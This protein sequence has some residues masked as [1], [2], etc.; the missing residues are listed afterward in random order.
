[1]ISSMLTVPGNAGNRVTMT[2]WF[3]DLQCASARA[4]G[5]TFS[6]TN[7]DCARKC[8]EKNSAAAFISEQA[9]AHYQ[10]KGYSAVLAR[11]PPA[12]PKKPAK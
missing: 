8:L 5:G 2:G 3:S 1:M 12:R 7:P 10:V 11:A 6:A 9:K 4:Q